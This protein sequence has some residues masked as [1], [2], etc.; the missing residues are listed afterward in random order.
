MWCCTHH[1]VSLGSK[2]LNPCSTWKRINL[3]PYNRHDTF[4][5]MEQPQVRISFS[6]HLPKWFAC[7]ITKGCLLKQKNYII[8]PIISL[9]SISPQTLLWLLLVLETM[10]ES[11]LE[12]PEVTIHNHFTVLHNTYVHACAFTPHAICPG[13][14]TNSHMGQCCLIITTRPPY[15]TLQMHRRAQP[16]STLCQNINSTF[17]C[18]LQY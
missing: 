10:S 8:P 16:M 1:M 4:L 15:N 2:E 6:A 11:P 13:T 5:N 9:P 3:K 17:N 12:S 7:H 14:L 18:L